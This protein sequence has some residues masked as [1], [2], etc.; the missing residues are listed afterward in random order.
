LLPLLLAH[1]LVRRVRTIDVVVD[2]VGLPNPPSAVRRL[3]APSLSDYDLS[4]YGYALLIPAKEYEFLISRKN[5]CTFD[6]AKKYALSISLRKYALLI[7]LKKYALFLI[8]RKNM[9]FQSRRKNIHLRC[10]EKYALLI[11]RKNMHF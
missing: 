10:G 2:P 8:P 3:G 11:P 7:L 9:H 1:G 6:P 5:M 4:D